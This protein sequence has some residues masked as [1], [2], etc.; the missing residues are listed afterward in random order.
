ME[1]SRGFLSTRPSDQL[2]HTSLAFTSLTRPVG[3][4]ITAGV[5]SSLETLHTDALAAQPDAR[6]TDWVHVCALP[7]RHQLLRLVFFPSDEVM[8]TQEVK[9][10]CEE[11]AR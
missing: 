1:K 4:P 6:L 11:V 8:G 5:M 3:L 7:R 2:D 10:E 9:E